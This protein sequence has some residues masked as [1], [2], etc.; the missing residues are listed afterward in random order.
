MGQVLGLIKVSDHT[1]ITPDFGEIVPLPADD[2]TVYQ[3][4]FDNFNGYVP[5]KLYAYVT[6]GDEGEQITTPPFF[7]DETTTCN[8]L[9]GI[10]FSDTII[11]FMFLDDE[12]GTTES[13]TFSE[14]GAIVIGLI[15]IVGAL[16]F[17]T[18]IATAI[19]VAISVIVFVIAIDIGNQSNVSIPLVSIGVLDMSA[20]QA[21]REAIREAKPKN[22]KEIK[23][24]FNKLHTANAGGIPDDGEAPSITPIHSSCLEFAKNVKAAITS[25][26]DLLKL[27][28]QL[29]NLPTTNNP[30]EVGFITQ[31]SN[32]GVKSVLVYSNDGI[33]MELNTFA[34]NTTLQMHTHDVSV[35]GIKLTGD[36]EYNYGKGWKTWKQN[37]LPV[38]ANIPHSVRNGSEDATFLS[39]FK[40]GASILG[41]DFHGM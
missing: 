7:I 2:T 27:N 14:I 35:L 5:T 9:V 34:S 28:I 32:P 36:L 23:S 24:L 40:S 12:R 39:I 33:K 37:I 19:C 20:M 1:M 26:T 13:G 4:I 17:T 11:D 6:F 41:N 31:S 16:I 18:N 22:G 10:S 3:Y 25:E 15:I 30:D 8:F 38:G 29:D 21:I